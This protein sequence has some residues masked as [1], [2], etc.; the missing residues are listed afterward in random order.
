MLVMHVDNAKCASRTRH[1]SH[2]TPQGDRQ[3]SYAN[4]YREPYPLV[5]LVRKTTRNLL[6]VVPNFKNAIGSL[7]NKRQNNNWSNF[8]GLHVRYNANIFSKHVGTKLP[9]ELYK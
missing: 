6:S 5:Q 3:F 1:I 8:I 9:Y 2:Y 7:S 4:F